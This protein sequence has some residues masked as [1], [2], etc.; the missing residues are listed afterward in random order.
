MYC[1]DTCLV[2]VYDF[3][4]IGALLYGRV[5]WV[6]S[7]GIFFTDK[8]NLSEKLS[9]SYRRHIFVRSYVFA[10]QNRRLIVSP[11]VYVTHWGII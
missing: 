5:G 1:I 7:R 6:R 11:A 8:R 3:T 9:N 2:G 10:I 4:T